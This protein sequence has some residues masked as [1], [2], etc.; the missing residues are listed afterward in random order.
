MAGMIVSGFQFSEGWRVLRSSPGVLPGA[1]TWLRAAVFAFAAA[2][3]AACSSSPK[4][5]PGAK[6]HYKVGNPY[7]VGGRWYYPK[8]DRKYDRVGVASWYGKQFHGRATANG[9]VFDMR[10]MSAAHPTLPLP[11]MVEVRNLDNG[12]RAVLRVNDR[13]PFAKGRIIDV[14]RAAARKLGFE[15]NGTARVRVR[16][17]G[18]ARLADA[19]PRRDEDVRLASG[20]SETGVGDD[21]IF[22]ILQS[23]RAE[24]AVFGEEALIAEASPAPG[25]D[26]ELLASV[27]AEIAA[28]TATPDSAPAETM[29]IATI[30]PPSP[31]LAPLRVSTDIEPVSSDKE[32]IIDMELAAE[33]FGLKTAYVIEVA[34]ISDPAALPMVREAFGDIDGL[35][36]A[37]KEDDAGKPVFVV[38]MG[39][40]DDRETAEA[41]LTDVIEAGFADAEIVTK[42]P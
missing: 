42:T 29:A 1:G 8:V 14:S 11:T 33:E 6:P 12:K 3:L 24:E 34:S 25:L 39:P 10:R 4:G 17:L 5:S 13:G 31:G 37:Q 19:A 41:R 21:E 28:T 32:P 2:G 35:F 27:D 36:I 20:P 7:Q 16:Y 26:T 15:V 30:S 9:E 23:L 18:E 38:T 22:D 40:F